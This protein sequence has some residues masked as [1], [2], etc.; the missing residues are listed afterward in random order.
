MSRTFILRNLTQLQ[1]F[2]T[3]F[4]KWSI[5]S[6]SLGYPSSTNPC[7]FLAASL[8][9]PLTNLLTSSSG[10]SSP[11]LREARARAPSEAGPPPASARARRCCPRLKIQERKELAD[12]FFKSIGSY[13]L[14]LLRTVISRW[15]IGTGTGSRCHYGLKG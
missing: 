4:W 9:A 1:V 5:C 15:D 8:T 2:L 6:K 11:P 10:T 13:K 7:S 12:L 14:R 3:S